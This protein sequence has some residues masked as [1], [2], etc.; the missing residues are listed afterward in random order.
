MILLYAQKTNRVLCLRWALK[1]ESWVGSAMGD[2][3]GTLGHPEHGGPCEQDRSTTEVFPGAA[4][5]VHN[6]QG[7]GEGNGNPLQYSCLGNP[8]EREEPG[9]LQPTESQRAGHNLAT[10]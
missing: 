3:Q 10:K 4:L 8:M 6:H 9:K 2:G 1:Q 7:C 5:H